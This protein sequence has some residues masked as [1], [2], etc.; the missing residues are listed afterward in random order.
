MDSFS[1]GHTRVDLEPWNTLGMRY[2]PVDN[3]IVYYLTDNESMT[4]LIVRVFYSG[5]DIKDIIQSENNNI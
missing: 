1:E 2:L 5:R 3:Y 4:V